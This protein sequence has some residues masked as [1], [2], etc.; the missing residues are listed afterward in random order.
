[1]VI[2]PMITGM[3]MNSR[4]IADAMRGALID[5]IW[6]K[7]YPLVL[8]REE[9][10]YFTNLAQ[11]WTIL[12]AQEKMIVSQARHIWTTSKAAG[13]LEEGRAYEAYARHGFRF[14]KEKMWDP[15]YGGF[16][17]IRDRTGGVSAAGGWRDEKRTYGNA[18]ALFALAALYERTHDPAVLDFAQTAFRWIETHAFDR[19]DNGYFQF[20]TADSQPFDRS[21]LYATIADDRDELGYKDQNSSIHLLEAYT[22]LYRLW[23]DPLLEAQLKNLLGLIR[24]VMTDEKGYLHLFFHPDWTPVSFR[25]SGD[26]ER[27]RYEGLDHVSFGHDV[28]TAF[29]ML[30]ASHALGIEEDTRTLSTARRMVDHALRCGFDRDNGGIHDAGYYF[31]GEDTCSIIRPTKNWW[32]QAE[33]LNALLLFSSIYPGESTYAEH[34]QKQW[35]YVDAYVLDHER[36]DWF[37]GGLDEQPEFRTGPK[38]HMW[39]CTYHTSRALMNCIMMLDDIPRRESGIHRTSHTTA[40]AE[41]IDHWRRTASLLPAS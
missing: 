27:R 29:L 32:A 7:W 10:G 23:H 39:K 17:Q 37:E 2:F 3:T 30:E 18:F 35:A 11:D 31:R 33:A 28:E 21:S 14:L 25:T 16:F 9:G 38:S 40:M 15:V 41:F 6:K 4:G 22:E 34:F 12:P 24:D 13:Y 5:G 26:E 1:M 36:G 19:R 8:D 20:L